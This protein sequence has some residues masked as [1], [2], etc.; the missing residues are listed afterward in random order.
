[1]QA[2][3][4]V[5]ASWRADGFVLAYAPL[6]D[7]Q[8]RIA[9]ITVAG[10]PPI[11]DLQLRCRS[12]QAG[13]G[14]RCDDAD[15]S[16]TLPAWGK[17]KGRLR[18]RFRNAQH[19][20][21][22]LEVPGRKLQV[23]LDQADEQL[24]VQ[25]R[26]KAQPAAELH[27][28]ITAMGLPLPGE[29]SGLL[30]LTADIRLAG[31]LLAVTADISTT[32]LNYSEPTGRY[33]AEKLTAKAQLDWD[34][35]R[36]RLQL[37]IDAQSGQ[38]YAEPVFFD[39]AALPLH[40][41][42]AIARAGPGWRIEQL[43]A[44]QGSA[45]TLELTGLLG[46]DY[47]PVTLDARLVAQDLGP[48]LA[49]DGL[50]FLIGTKLDSISARGRAEVKVSMREGVPQE[51]VARLDGV[52]VNAEKLGVSLD[53]ISGDLNWSAA[54]S[55]AAGSK[56]R[57]RGG[58]I[59]RVPLG[60]S[61]IEFMAQGK[62]VR[63]TAPWRQPLLG[64]A[65]K[66]ERLALRDLGGV[67]FGAQFNGALEPIDLAA[68]CRALGWPEFGGTLGGQLPGLTVR[69]EVWSMDGALEAQAFDGNIRIDQLR[70]IQPFG[71]LPRVTADVS[72]RRLDLERLTSAFSFGRITGRLD[73]EV[74]GLR[75]LSWSPV[76]F[77]G[78]LYSTPG[79]S[80]NRRISQ[81][82]IDNISSIGGGP[83]GLVS[84]GF[85]RVFEDFAYARLGIGCVLRDG[86]CAMDGVE[87]AKSKD[88]QAAYY[89]VRGRL[90][91]RID[92]VG[93][94]QRVSWSSL[95]EQLE[96]ARASGGPELK[97]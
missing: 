14:A 88:G 72:V 26:L 77:D 84:R 49:T 58:T 15:F 19:W 21:A 86:V 41:S 64:G 89:L 10:R 76:A 85:L 79:Y 91:P 82:A 20:N 35:V 78:R 57:W 24:Q 92:V 60:E 48:L 62:N 95:I 34:A 51:L 65:L 25:L 74:K 45:G 16:V 38:A 7:L 33:A 3:S 12:L 18:A 31:A 22:Q 23:L 47:K 96:A 39:F 70:A 80:G 61:N 32:D 67:Q 54:D 55:G 44:E 17:V 73:G 30:D 66:V 87:P 56:I 9:A 90:L 28:L 52:T 8:L 69:D 13:Q 1:M 2:D 75:L 50:P 43:K 97:K 68:L 59:M 71:R 93:Y 53:D 83:T 5:A 81:R 37:A 36:G 6:N 11:R 42:G 46:K 40:A 29:S 27:R 63:L 4:V 94:A